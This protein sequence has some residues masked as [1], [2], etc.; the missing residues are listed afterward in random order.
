M[1]LIVPLGLTLIVSTVSCVVV[2]VLTPPIELEWSAQ[3]YAKVRPFGAWAQARKSAEALG[4]KMAPELSA[5]LAA[6][7]VVVGLVASFSLFVSPVYFLGRWFADAATCALIFCVCV[8]VL[9][10]TWYRRLPSD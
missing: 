5:P 4:L 10:F 8:T 3:F 9:F 6:L 7:N 2:S 1:S